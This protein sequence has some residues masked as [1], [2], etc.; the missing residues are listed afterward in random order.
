MKTLLFGLIAL[1]QMLFIAG[2]ASVAT[3]TGSRTPEPRRFEFPLTWGERISDLRFFPGGGSA[4]TSKPRWNAVIPVFLNER[5]PF[6]LLVDTGAETTFISS[7]I[8]TPEG[9]VEYTTITGFGGNQRVAVSKLD[10]LRIGNLTFERPTVHI[11]EWEMRHEKLGRVDGVLAQD[12]LSG[13]QVTFDYPN[14][15]LILV[16]T[17]RKTIFRGYR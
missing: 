11:G 12:L 8:A 16:D 5:D 9:D 6:L 13:F 2:C 14:E 1:V 4:W 3:D 10:S 17:R 7:R 15:K